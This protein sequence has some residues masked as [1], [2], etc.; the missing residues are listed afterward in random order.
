MI[1]SSFEIVN[2]WYHMVMLST[3]NRD[4]LLVHVKDAKRPPGSSTKTLNDGFRNIP[5]CR[6]CDRRSVIQPGTLDF[7]FLTGPRVSICAASVCQPNKSLVGTY[8]GLSQ[9][10]VVRRIVDTDSIAEN[11]VAACDEVAGSLKL[12]ATLGVRKVEIHCDDLSAV[13]YSSELDCA[14]K[15]C[16]GTASA[17][18]S[19]CILA[20]VMLRSPRSTEPIYV[21]W[22]PARSA[23]ASCDRPARVRSSRTRMP[24][25]RSFVKRLSLHLPDMVSEASA[26][27]YFKSTDYE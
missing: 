6:E 18:A 21:R 2:N 5:A 26:N 20:S 27:G 8:G 23:S 9:E 3:V 15:L 10:C 16:T 7:H 4:Q 22:S 24:N 14:N 19:A 11:S 13:Q 12:C 1:H 25:A 17:S